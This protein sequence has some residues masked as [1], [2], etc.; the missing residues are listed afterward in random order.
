MRR[1]DNPHDPFGSFN[2]KL[3]IDGVTAAGFSEVTGLDTE[4]EVMDYR[5]GNEDITIRKLPGLKKFS[6]I[7]LKRGFS[8]NTELFDWRKTVMDG[9]IER[10]N[11]SIIL[12]D[13]SGSEKIRWNLESAWPCKWVGAELKASANEIAVETLELCHERMDMVVS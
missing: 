12:C 5:E 3:E 1:D 4:T 8:T 7:T 11:V 9:T 2:F 13:E 10:K 6:N